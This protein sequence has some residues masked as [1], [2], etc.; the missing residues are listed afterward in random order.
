MLRGET[1]PMVPSWI[2]RSRATCAI[3][4]PVSRTSRTAPSLKSSSNFL[5]VSAIARHFPLKGSLH[6]TWGDS[7]HGPVVDT[8]VSGHLRDR[9]TRLPDQPDRALLEVQLELP[10]RLCHRPSLPS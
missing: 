7:P 4:L 8:K 2:P 6:A 10:A 9:L 1:H 3:G 5:R